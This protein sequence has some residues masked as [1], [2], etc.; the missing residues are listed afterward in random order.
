[1][2]VPAL[3]GLVA[4]EE[5]P[6]AARRVVR[7][8]RPLAPVLVRL[9]AVEEPAG[10]GPARWPVLALRAVVVGTAPARWPPCRARS[11]A[12]GPGCGPAAPGDAAEAVRMAYRASLAAGAP[13]SQRAMLSGSG[14]HAAAWPASPRRSPR[15][16]PAMRPAGLPHGRLPARLPPPD[17][18][19]RRIPA[20]P[21]RPSAGGA[22]ACQARAARRGRARAASGGPSRNRPGAAAVVVGTGPARWPV[23]VLRLAAVESCPAPRPWWSATGLALWP[24]RRPADRRQRVGT[25]RLRGRHEARTAAVSVRRDVVACSGID[26]CHGYVTLGT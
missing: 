2:P 16:A 13:L 14:Y 4:V 9:V 1:M 19:T 17:H 26:D 11:R 15:N 22:L 23:P 5:L 21:R 18:P 24:V 10:I 7:L 12:R 25:R 8:A 3:A 20:A 6:G